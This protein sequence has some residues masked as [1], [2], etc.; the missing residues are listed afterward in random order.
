MT[1]DD[2]DVPLAELPDEDDLTEIAD[3][4]VPLAEL[5]EDNLTEIEDQDVPLA[6]LPE[7]DLTEIED[8]DVPLADV[9]KTG[10]SSMIWNVL[11]VLSGTGLVLLALD[12]KRKGS[13]E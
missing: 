11:A 3:Q 12:K 2:P 7:D 8:Q 5:P 6:E 4:D 13:V 1:I 10:D 9:P